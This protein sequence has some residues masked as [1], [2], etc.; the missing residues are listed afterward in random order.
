M[1]RAPERGSA[2]AH[3]G[4]RVIT[5]RSVRLA[6]AT[7]FPEIFHPGADAGLATP[8]PIP[9]TVVK[10]IGPMVLAKAERVGG[11]RGFYFRG[12]SSAHAARRRAPT[13][14][15]AGSSVGAVPAAA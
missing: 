15:R 14:F 9:N 11:C 3:E 13:L 5:T 7:A 10:Q 8:V 4:R 12:P 1:E 2:E 6:G